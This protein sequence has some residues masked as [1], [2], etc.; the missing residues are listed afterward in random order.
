[1]HIPVTALSCITGVHLFCF[2]LVLGKKSYKSFQKVTLPTLMSGHLSQT[3]PNWLKVVILN[4][5]S[6]S[7]LRNSGF[8]S[9]LISSIPKSL[10]GCVF[11]G[12][13][14]F[15]FAGVHFLVY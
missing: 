10:H 11:L 15:F 9:A 5:H 14:L 8:L 7:L 13:F 6:Y 1:M 12:A 3:L 2:M 4:I